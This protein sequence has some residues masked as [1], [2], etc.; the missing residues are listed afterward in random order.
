ME[1]V[2]N[3]DLFAKLLSEPG[4]S[5]RGVL[6]VGCEAVGRVLHGR[7][8]PAFGIDR[9]PGMIEIARRDRPGL[10][11]RVGSMTAPEL[12]DVSL[13][14]SSPSGRSSTCRTTSY[15]RPS[16]NSIACSR[17][18]GSCSSGKTSGYS[19]HPMYV[20]VHRWL[21]A[22]LTAVA[23]I[24]R[25]IEITIDGACPAV[26][27]EPTS[28]VAPAS[29]QTWVSLAGCQAVRAALTASSA[30]STPA[31]AAPGLPMTGVLASSRE[32][33]GAPRSGISA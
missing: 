13:A 17:P 6:D 24:I 30:N 8:L 15:R 29:C 26:R 11:F 14:A 7:G 33:R 1:E 2:T 4:L 32:A 9:S 5:G 18:A 28:S 31:R 25:F 16:R 12:P 27:A 21:A 22:V 23:R 20:H 3:L 10:A 19:D